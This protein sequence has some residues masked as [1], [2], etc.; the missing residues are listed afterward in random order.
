M[1]D[2]KC[3]CG[4]ILPEVAD[5][6]TPYEFCSDACASASVASV[7]VHIAELAD[8]SA[9]PALQSSQYNVDK[10][11]IGT[12]KYSG[13]AWFHSREYRHILRSPG[14]YA[15]AKGLKRAPSTRQWC[16]KYKRIHDSLLS[17]GLDVSGNSPEHD[18]IVYGILGCA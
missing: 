1:N 8:R 2:N 6:E 4:Y 9:D 7:D 14:D 10:R 16:A 17:A 18:E 5:D 11:N 12:S 15:D 13:I 3:R